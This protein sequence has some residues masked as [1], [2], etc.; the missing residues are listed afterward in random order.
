MKAIMT[1]L[2]LLL[3]PCM[4]LAQYKSDAGQVNVSSALQKSL[5]SGK[6][7]IGVLGLD[8]NKLSITQSYSMSYL[9]MG[10][11]SFSQGMYLNTMTYHFKLPVE[12]SFQW[13]IAH[14]P[15]NFTG[16]APFYNQGPFIRGANLSFK[17]AKNVSIQVEFNNDPYG[18]GAWNNW[19]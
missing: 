16:N 14:Q 4:A 8:P 6:N 15:L 10:G 5:Q 12:L 11:N 9:S 17:P 2:L 19:R 3:L 7:A 1:C 18:Y 13:G